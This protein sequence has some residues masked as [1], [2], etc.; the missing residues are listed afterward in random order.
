MYM[1]RAM[2]TLQFSMLI[3][4]IVPNIVYLIMS[5][6]YRFRS[7]RVLQTFDVEGVIQHYVGK[8]VDDNGV[9]FLLRGPGTYYIQPL[10]L[11]TEGN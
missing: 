7:I 2:T 11:S 9:P 10:I 8:L 3:L 5:L 6:Y 1:T 4:S